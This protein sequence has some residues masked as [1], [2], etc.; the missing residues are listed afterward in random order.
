M[1]GLDW[2]SAKAGSIPWTAVVWHHSKGPDRPASD[3]EGIRRYHMKERGWD[4]IG[5]HFG[6]EMVD[7]A[8]LVRV[9]RGLTRWGAHTIGMNKDSIG[10]CVIGD[11]D[12][13]RPSDLILA[14]CVE[15]GL[16]ISREFPAIT[17]N[18]HF[19]HRHFTHEKTCPGRLFPEISEFRSMMRRGGVAVA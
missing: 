3:W 2:R 17:I 8:P 19:Y 4:D 9:G 11:Y 6:I 16:E 1:I 14:A 10:I 18:Q 7:G 13:A 5:Y 12:A 15:L